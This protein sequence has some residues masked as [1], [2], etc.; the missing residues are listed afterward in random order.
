MQVYVVGGAVRNAL[1][2]TPINDIDYVVVGSTEQQ[3]LD[4]GFYRV[5]ADFPVFLDDEGNEYALARTE[6]S[7]GPGYNEFDCEFSPDVTLQDDQ[8]RRDLT[9]NQ[10]A[11]RIEDWST[12]KDTLDTSLVID[13][14]GGLGDIKTKT[15]RHISKHF[16]DDSV[17]ILRACRFAAT[18]DLT[19]HTATMTLMKRMVNAGVIEHLVPERVY[20]EFEKSLNLNKPM[21]FFWT[22]HICGA[23]NILVPGLSSSMTVNGISV[24]A[25]ALR[26]CSLG[27]KIMLMFGFL[28]DPTTALQDIKAPTSWIRRA[29]K[30]KDAYQLV[31]TS[32]WTAT[33]IDDFLVSVGSNK[34]ILFVISTALCIM[35]FD[36]GRRFDVVLLANDKASS[37]CF[38]TLSEHQQQNL[39]GVE[40]GN[41]I[42]DRRVKI[43]NSLINL[44]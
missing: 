19:I 11:V 31:T 8:L 16:S 40:I 12:F 20:A 25:A 32:S 41:A 24:R 23:L 21:A 22:M 30:F 38:A 15:I 29:T 43:I 35:S 42:K 4:Q 14:F 18:Y 17:R 9:I 28:N 3:M 27:V 7:T 13:S 44:K 1:F 39:T 33:D 6:R 26:E 10:L 34:S 5:G 36:M 2:R 37:E